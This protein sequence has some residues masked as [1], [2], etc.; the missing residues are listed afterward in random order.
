MQK[1]TAII[2]TVEDGIGGGIL[3]QVLGVKEEGSS[4]LGDF[5]GING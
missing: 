5:S 2:K 4:T 3:F 1:F